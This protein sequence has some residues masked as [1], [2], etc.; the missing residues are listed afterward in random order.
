M[1]SKTFNTPIVPVVIDGSYEALGTGMLFPRPRKIR[2]TFL[3]P[4]EPHSMEQGEIVE[5]VRG[6]IQSEL[7][8]AK[9]EHL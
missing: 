5:R 3:K 2:V 4:I 1:L 9:S 6:A 8:K 7:K